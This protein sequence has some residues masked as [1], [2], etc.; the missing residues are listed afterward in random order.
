MESFHLSKLAFA[1][2]ACFATLILPPLH[3]AASSAAAFRVFSA[4]AADGAVAAPLTLD[5]PSVI[6]GLRDSGKADGRARV[7]GIKEI[8]RAELRENWLDALSCPFPPAKPS[9]EWVIGVDPDVSGALAILKPDQS[10]QVFDS[11]HLKVMVGKGLRS[12]LDAK[13]IV[14]LLRSSEVPVGTTAFIEQSSPYPQD[15]KQGWW[16]GGFGYGLWIGIL[17]A[18]GFTVVPVPSS[19]WKRYFKL[20]GGHLNKDYSREMACKLFPSMSLHLKRKKDHGRAEALLIAAYGRGL[21]MNC[22]TGCD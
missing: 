4:S 16:G 9:T 2:P 13:S 18:L 6:T 7:R 21:E 5:S 20:P 3:L 17:V 11:P 12:R 22:K 8:Q 10:P 1:P 15:G 19:L 14:N